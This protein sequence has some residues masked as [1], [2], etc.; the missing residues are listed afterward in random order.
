M[1]QH[2]LPTEVRISK[3]DKSS[4]KKLEDIDITGIF[5]QAIRSK[6]DFYIY[7]TSSRYHY[8]LIDDFD[9]DAFILFSDPSAFS[10]RFAEAVRAALPDHTVGAGPVQYFDPYDGPGNTVDPLFWKHFRYAYQS[11]YRFVWVPPQDRKHMEPIFVGLGPLHDIAE[12]FEL[13]DAFD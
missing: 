5:R 2:L 1:G 10:D 7:C 13:E 12:L 6:T 4:R 9:A 11:E 3:I 8:R